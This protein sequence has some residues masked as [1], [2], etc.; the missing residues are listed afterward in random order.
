MTSNTHAP[1]PSVVVGIDGSRFGVN[2]ALWAIDEAIERDIPLRLV[3][4]IDSHCGPTDPEV[5]ARALAAADIAVRHA[6]VAIESTGRPVKVEVEILQGRPTDKLLE[7]SR[8]AALMCVGAV[9]VKHATAGPIGSTAAELAGRALCPL[10]V[11]R[12]FAPTRTEP[13]AVVVEIDKTSDGDAVLQRAIDEALLRR[14]PLV[15][16]SVWE[17]DV[18]DVHDRHAVATQNHGVRADLNRRLARAA[19][20]HPGLDVRPVAVRGSLLNYLSHHAHSTQLVVV[21]LRRLHGATEMLGRGG[22]AALQGTT[23]ALLVCPPSG[24]L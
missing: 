10:A 16:I 6:F 5:S 15:A 23:C 3:Y 8:A 7:A 9:G 11:V 18:T 20:R 13:G 1:S 2:A 19:R 21:G 17:P 24:H 22:H 14:A 4:V 12:G